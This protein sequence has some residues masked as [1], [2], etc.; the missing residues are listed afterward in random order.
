MFQALHLIPSAGADFAASA[1]DMVRDTARSLI[2]ALGGVCLALAVATAFDRGTRF[3]VN[4]WAV[5]PLL[6]LCSL[7]AYLLLERCFVLAQAIWLT[8]VASAALLEMVVS[9]RPEAILIL[10][11]V[12]FAAVLSLGWHAGLAAE[13]G[14]GA[15]VLWVLHSP[16]MPAL[17]VPLAMATVLG[18]AT[19]ALLAWA[20][21]RPLLAA[22]YWSAQLYEQAREKMDQAREQGLE[23][24]Q[25][26]ED[27][28]QANRELARLSDRLRA[29]YR[30]AEEARRAKEEFVANVSH[31]LRTPLN[32]IIGFS[33]MIVEAPQIY[34]AKLP[35]ALL[36]DIAAI[37]LNSRN[38][39]RLVD[40]V[41][42]LSQVEAGRMALTKE[43]THLPGLIEAAVLAVRPLLEAK[44]LTL[45]AEVPTD[46]PPLFCD[47]TRVRQVV[48]NLLSNAGRFTERGG[49]RIRAQCQDGAVV[50]GVTDTGPG[51]APEDQQRLF[52]P[53]QQLD[54]S[55]R[56]RHGGSGLGL[57]ISKRFVEMH[58]GRMWLESQ[59]GVGT[60]FFFSLPVETPVPHG[61]T[62]AE[63]ALRWF[64]PYDEVEYRLR[65]RPFKA[66][67]PVAVPRFV[68]LD[69]GQ[70]LSRIFTRYLEGFDTVTVSD[71]NEA[72][73]ELGRSP[74]QGLV[75]NASPFVEQPISREQLS[76]LPYNTPAVTCWVPGED[77]TA[78]RLGVVRYLVKPVNRETLLT[79]LDE[80]QK[81]ITS[82]LVVDDEADAL[83]LFARML[84]SSGRNYQ[85]LRAKSGLRALSLLRERRPDVMLLDLIMPGMDGF[86][87]LEAKAQDAAIRDVPVVV[88]S[89]RDPQGEP[90][91][92]D[93]LTVTRAGGLSVRD[94]LACIRALSEILSP[95]RPPSDRE[96]PGTP[97]A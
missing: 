86:Q 80:L 91:V 43:W 27:L 3:T 85:I 65:T 93:M 29:M 6:G 36:S 17:S 39:A 62:R 87:V 42:D 78:R 81:P 73:A 19:V 92:S 64:N 35:P 69:R 57:A 51:I 83:R 56:R 14:V 88:V 20:A 70:T 15:L 31:E 97:A 71:A 63:T 94:L 32:M 37:H 44:G 11:L 52:E 60:T 47:S 33:E 7:A 41:L 95:P 23:L 28:I 79:A 77:E 84:A 59:P 75:I 16:T 24:Q 2:L 58:G 8:G 50:V 10:G 67:P 46:L 22:A 74:A 13:A 9:Q 68:L 26:R 45:E 48:L 96:S 72:L 53:F 90:I 66:P 76:A 30:V 18:G 61:Q 38:L 4:V 82:V 34:G 40:D 89:S 21:Q 1:R 55:I 5:V 12:P 25:V 49:I 54:G